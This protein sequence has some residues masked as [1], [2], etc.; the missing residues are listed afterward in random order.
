MFNGMSV[1]IWSM[2]AA[3]AKT[4]MTAAQSG[5][6]KS[7]GSSLRQAGTFIAMIVMACAFNIYAQMEES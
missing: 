3:K 4:G 5:E 1:V 7:V 2:I 6:S